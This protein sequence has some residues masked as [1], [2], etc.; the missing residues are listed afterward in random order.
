MASGGAKLH[1]MIGKISP[2]L[3]FTMVFTGLIVIAMRLRG[4]LAG[5]ADGF[6]RVLLSN[7]PLILS[8]L[9]LFAL[10][11]IAG[12]VAALTNRFESHKRLIIL[13]SSAGLGAAVFR[14]FGV[15]I[16]FGEW[17]V[18]Y[19]MLATNAFV[20]I[21]M[22]YDKFS[23]GSVH[24]TYWVGLAIA[25]GVELTVSPFHGNPIVGPINAALAALAPYFE[26]LY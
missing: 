25:V 18:V 2:L 16:G 10:F 6:A 14:V 23:R 7:G 15:L 20:I 13:A 4:A 5:D 8:S 11:Y 24:I 12:V 9:L 26:V 1:M 3:V 22:I 19:A 17:T 21:G